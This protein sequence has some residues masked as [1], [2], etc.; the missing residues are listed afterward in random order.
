MSHWLNPIFQPQMPPLPSKHSKTILTPKASSP[1]P[2]PPGRPYKPPTN[3]PGINEL[4]ADC[5]R[6]PGSIGLRRFGHVKP[7]Q[8]LNR[9]MTAQI[10]HGPAERKRCQSG[11]VDGQRPP[12]ASRKV[13][14]PTR[15][16][17]TH[18]APRWSP[19]P[20]LFIAG[21]IGAVL[22]PLGTDRAAVLT[23]QG[24]KA[25]YPLESQNQEKNATLL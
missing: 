4:K 20:A 10:E 2:Q 5:I 24:Q 14:G 8:K 11:N 9:E 3:H 21:Q 15:K 13:K 6:C 16:R 12:R 19:S 25:P 23:T 22:R 1:K 7:R 17:C 18:S